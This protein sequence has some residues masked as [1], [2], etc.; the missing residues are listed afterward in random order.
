MAASPCRAPSRNL[1]LQ[2]RVGSSSSDFSCCRCS[3][4]PPAPTP[5]GAPSSSPQSS[6]PSSVS[7]SQRLVVVLQPNQACSC[8]P[9]SRTDHA[10]FSS[11]AL[12]L[13]HGRRV[14]SLWCSAPSYFLVHGRGFLSPSLHLSLQLATPSVGSPWPPRVARPARSW[15]WPLPA[16]ACSCTDSMWW[17]YP[18]LE[19]LE[20]S[21]LSPMARAAPAR[22]GP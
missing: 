7:F 8:A 9:D 6:T 3:A 2:S 15:R 19:L 1:H 12:P 17:V 5:A 20:L 22:I 10:L 21:R 11:P 16:A 13:F 18:F 14:P 4:Q